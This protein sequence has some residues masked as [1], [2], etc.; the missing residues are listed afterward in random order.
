MRYIVTGGA[1]FIG[2]NLAKKLVDDGH[3]VVVVD[4]FHTG[5]MENL[6][7]IRDKVRIIKGRSCD[8]PRLVLRDA[9]GVFHLGI[10]SSTPMYR[11]N[12]L[13]VG[14]AINEFIRILDIYD[15]YDGLVVFASSSSVYNGCGL[16]YNEDMALVPTDYYTEARIAME[17]LARVYH[18]M[19]GS[20]TVTLRMFSVY[21]PGERAKG[22]YANMVS[23]FLWEM[24]E[25]KRP[26]IYG[27][28]TQ[29]RDFVHVSDAVNA[30]ILAMGSRPGCDVFNVGT[31]RSYSFNDIVSL[32]NIALGTS[33]VIKPIYVENTLKNYVARTEADTT[34]ARRDLKFQTAVSLEAGILDLI[35][36]G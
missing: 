16:P 13:L 28:G 26:V 29:T 36:R 14:E 35:H 25:G 3:D 22:P 20:R 8:I 1:G 34:K 19:Y 5:S 23:Q 2:S 31:G 12:R 33:P 27:D 21:G 17:R 9:E 15:A 10:P 7:G 24:R 32:L 4:N 6:Q 11:E 18:D 30:F